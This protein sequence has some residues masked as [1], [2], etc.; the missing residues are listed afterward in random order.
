[1]RSSPARPR[2]LRA[3]RCKLDNRHCEQKRERDIHEEIT[4]C[5]RVGLHGMPP[6]TIIT[7]L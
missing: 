4:E 1:M 2:D 7:T 5:H 6:M 3:D